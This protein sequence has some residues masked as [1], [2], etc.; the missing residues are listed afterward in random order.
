MCFVKPLK[1]K[2]I[3]KK[4]VILENGMKAYYEKKIGDLKP[5]DQVI[6]YGNLILQKL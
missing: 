2:K 6:V 3:S 5:N 4:V 1:V